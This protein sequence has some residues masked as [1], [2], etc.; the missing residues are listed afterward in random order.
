MEGNVS[1]QEQNNT[2]K[3]AIN[4]S[5]HPD[6][7]SYLNS[8]IKQRI[9]LHKFPIH[10]TFFYPQRDSY[11]SDGEVVEVR[12]TKILE[13]VTGSRTIAFLMGNGLAVFDK[14]NFSDIYLKTFL[15]ISELS[16]VLKTN[17]ETNM[18]LQYVINDAVPNGTYGCSSLCPQEHILPICQHP[19]LV[20]IPGQCCREWMCDSQTAEQPPSCQ[21]AFSRWSTC[22]NACGTGLSTRR[23]NLNARCQP[24]TGNSYMPDEKVFRCNPNRL[25]KK[26]SSSKGRPGKPF[27]GGTT[28]LSGGQ[29][30]RSPFE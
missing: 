5:R 14:I 22:S 26:V 15:G 27:A 7:R 16:R 11:I 28:F 21:P 18:T 19:R 23:S 20:E 9:C 24:N 25:S 2:F 8:N 1:E 6:V 30:S 4:K 3:S 17:I 12:V 29:Y 10:P 13:P